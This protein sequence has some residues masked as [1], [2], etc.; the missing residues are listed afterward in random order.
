MISLVP[1]PLPSFLFT[2]PELTRVTTMTPCW[3][4]EPEAYTCVLTQGD[5]PTYLDISLKLIPD[6]TVMPN[7]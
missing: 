5:I 7:T 3:A 2:T 4:R 1:D 6:K